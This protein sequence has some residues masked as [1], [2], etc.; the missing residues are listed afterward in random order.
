VGHQSINKDKRILENGKL[1]PYD[2]AYLHRNLPIFDE[3][4]EKTNWNGKPEKNRVANPMPKSI[5]P[6]YSENH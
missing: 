3:K 5:L 6:K 1:R 4:W 2:S